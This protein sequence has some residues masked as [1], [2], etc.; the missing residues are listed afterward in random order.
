MRKI[1]AKRTKGVNGKTLIVAVDIGMVTHTGYYRCP[2][3]TDVR[4]FEFFNNGRGF[5][6]FWERISQAMRTHDLKDVVVGFES[7]GPYAEPLVHYL[8]KRPVRLVQ[9]N[10]MHTKRLKELQ[11]NSPNKT[12]RKD[13]KVIADI[14]ELGHALTL[15]VPEG[16]AA[17][18]R[19]LTQARERE[20]QRRT[21][22]FNQLQHLV[23]I[24]FPEFLQEMKD[25]KTKSAQYLLKHH[26]TPPSIV[27]SGVQALSLILRKISRGQLGI[28]RAQALVE[29]A[30][31]SVGIQQGG[32]GIRYEIKHIVDVIETSERFIA[33]VEQKMSDHLKQIPYSRSIL[34][35][36]GIGEVTAA[37]LIGEVGD[38][39]QFRT[40]SEINKLA[41]LD[42]FEIS[43]GAHKGKRR[44][45]KRGRPLIRKLLFFAALNVVRRDGILHE[46]YQK[47]LQRGMLKMKAL[48]AIA[49]RLLGIIFALVRNHSEYVKG[50]TQT[51]NLLKEAA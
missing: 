29:A 36:K 39:H 9:V 1:K 20:S 17:E 23:F 40:I 27:E 49:R 5:Q 34:S 31:G 48:V 4:A 42:L 44:I 45:S 26:P 13:P 10:P 43:S 35:I 6:T 47:Y 8:R 25:I 38:F 11:G 12:D 14:I 18:L 19:R 32:E 30:R 22:L 51:Q 24:V 16:A 3:G 41:G 46:P 15:V 37:G 28:E 7:T 2:D 50:Y 33:D 21:A